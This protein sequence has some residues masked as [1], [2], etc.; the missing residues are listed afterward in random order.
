ML[1][2]KAVATFC[3]LQIEF[4]IDLI[5]ILSGLAEFLL[6]LTIHGIKCPRPDKF[7]RFGDIK[8]PKPYKFIGFGNIKCRRPYK[9][10]RF[11]DIKCPRPYKF[12]GFGDK[13]PQTL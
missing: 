8:C 1:G 11:G 9:F 4:V 7:I 3:E 12:I 13:V 2:P 10:I 5:K 6:G